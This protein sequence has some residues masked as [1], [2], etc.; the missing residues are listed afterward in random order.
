MG[1]LLHLPGWCRILQELSWVKRERLEKVNKMREEERTY[2]SSYPL[3]PEKNNNKS[4]AIEKVFGDI[5]FS[6]FCKL[7]FQ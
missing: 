7:A 1:L 3:P 2:V 4:S 6:S 5:Y